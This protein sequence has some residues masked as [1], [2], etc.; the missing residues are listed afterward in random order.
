ML[1]DTEREEI[2]A[3]MTHYPAPEHACIDALKI[4]QRH[5]GWVSDEGVQDIAAFLH[6][7]PAEVDSVATFYN[8][9]FRRPV[10]THVIM[11][12]DSVSCWIV[13]YDQIREQ[14]AAELGIGL[15]E[16]TADGQFTLLPIP[17][18]GTCDHAPAMMIGEDLH[19]DLRP[20]QIGAILERYRS[21]EGT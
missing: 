11:L 15:G 5:R 4:V 2:A 6:I 12:C 16:T 1:S 19:R 7:S 8:L 20:E 21:S 17:C 18:L 3:E 13:G 9:I 10:G 14:L